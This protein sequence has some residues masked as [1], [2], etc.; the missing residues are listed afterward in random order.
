MDLACIFQ[1]ITSV[2]LYDVQQAD[3]ID[4]VVSQTGLR[5]IA[6]PQILISKLFSIKQ[7]NLIGTL[8]YIISFE[9]VSDQMKSEGRELGIEIMSLK[10]VSELV[11][12]GTDR[13][14]APD[15]FE[16]MSERKVRKMRIFGPVVYS[17]FSCSCDG[18]Y[19]IFVGYHSAFRLPC[20]SA[21]IAY[22]K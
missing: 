6:C 14:P 1:S 2:P 5:V 13:P 11:H 4:W 7:S 21:C 15:S 22:C 18:G 17:C 12:E 8:T 16:H 19:H 20:S 10:S 9:E 3:T